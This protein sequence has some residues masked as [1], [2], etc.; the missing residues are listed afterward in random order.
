MPIEQQSDTKQPFLRS[1]TIYL[2]PKFRNHIFFEVKDKHFDCDP[3]LIYCNPQNQPI[4]WMKMKANTEKKKCKSRHSTKKGLCAKTPKTDSLPNVLTPQSH[5][6]QTTVLYLLWH[7]FPQSP[8]TVDSIFWVGS[9]APSKKK[10]KN[11]FQ[12][13]RR[14]EKYTYIVP[15]FVCRTIWSSLKGVMYIF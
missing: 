10:I 15:A 5:F 9:E 8:Y 12:I 2:H 14:A 1:K 11:T 7:S 4:C 3:I 6:R 13:C